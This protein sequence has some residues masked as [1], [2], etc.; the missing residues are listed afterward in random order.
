MS[1]DWLDLAEITRFQESHRHLAVLRELLR[2][3]YL[4]RG[5]WDYALGDL[6][7]MIKDAVGAREAL[8]AL[9]QAGSATWS[10]V[11]SAGKALNEETIS[12]HASLS[13]LEH[14]RRTGK[15]VL[16]TREA[17][18]LRSESISRHGLHSVISVPLSWW[19]PSEDR[20][21]RVFGGC[22]YAD[23]AA[24]EDPFT[25]QDVELALDIAEIAQRTLNVL[26]HL[27]DVTTTLESTR[28]ELLDLRR[29]AAK[30]YALGDFTTRDPWFAKNVL[31]PL[32]RIS[33]AD[34]VC[35]LL[36]G[37]T[38]SGKSH[39]AHAYHFESPR[40]NRPF[41]VLDC[42]QVTSEQTLAAELFGYAPRSGFANAPEQGRA[43]AASLADGG[44]LFIDEIGCLSLELQQRFLSLLQTGSFSP[45]GSSQR[46][47]V[48]LQILAATNEALETQVQKGR[49][50]EDLMW[51]LSELIL[52]LPSLNDRPADIQPLAEQFLQRARARF[53]RGD[54]LGFTAP[55][56]TKLLR[57][58]W[59]RAGNIRGLEQTV[60]RSLLLAAPGTRLLEESDLRFSADFTGIEA[61]PAQPSQP[62]PPRRRGSRARPKPDLETIVASVR[63]HGSGKFAAD[64]LGITRGTLI[65]QLRKAGLTIGS[66]LDEA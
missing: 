52:R 58:D 3:D 39:L 59:S 31:V 29:A 5:D 33:K 57:H 7:R 11:T 37:P 47:T 62:D 4:T 2:N 26:R 13:V 55:A 22:I 48:D 8:V 65:W 15:P 21:E 50:R 17:L 16:T 12:R 61:L 20:P 30:D 28:V 18:E 25:E 19:D 35:L 36:L 45:L 34:R 24:E 43:G 44:T 9:S 6:A 1:T 66:I 32:Q 27:R 63:Q 42:A 49:F 56:L 10:A 64:E 53:G 54:G 14:V 23:R 51:R 41:I 46:K 60:H 38:G 40:R